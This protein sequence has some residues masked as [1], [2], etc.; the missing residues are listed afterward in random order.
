MENIIKFGMKGWNK[1]SPK[2]Q[3]RTLT[4][5]NISVEIRDMQYVDVDLKTGIKL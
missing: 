2:V 1:Q 3:L 4:L 5:Y